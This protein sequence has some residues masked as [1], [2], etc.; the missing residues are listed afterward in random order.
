MGKNFLGGN[1]GKKGARKHQNDSAT[2]KATRYA[3][4]SGEIYACVSRMYGGQHCEVTCVD[5]QARLCVIRNKFRGRGKRD[6]T[7]SIGVWVLIGERNW[8][9]PGEGKLSKCDLLEVYSTADRGRLKSSEKGVKWGMLAGIGEDK[10]IISDGEVEF[11]DA[12]TTHYDEILQT[13]TSRINFDNDSDASS[14]DIEDI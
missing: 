11:V 2:Q 5:G 4:E 10:G 1:K 7:L 8:E 3:K 13:Q 14:I 6:N 12:T 9:T